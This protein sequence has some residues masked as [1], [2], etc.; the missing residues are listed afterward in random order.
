MK[1]VTERVFLS[2]NCI[3][4]SKFS[5]DHQRVRVRYIC[6]ISVWECPPPPTHTLDYV[7]VAVLVFPVLVN[8]HQ[9]QKRA[10]HIFHK[11]ELVNVCLKH[12]FEMHENSLC[13]HNGNCNNRRCTKWWSVTLWTSVWKTRK[14]VSV[15]RLTTFTHSNQCHEFQ[16]LVSLIKSP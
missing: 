1:I 6:T 15:H 11:L 2:N 4:G 3:F 9:S 10:L 7:Y 14:L 16:K 5:S 8:L 13:H 12:S